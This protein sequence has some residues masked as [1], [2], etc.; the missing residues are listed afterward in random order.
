MVKDWN[1]T[2]QEAND[3]F[4]IKIE[5]DGY[6]NPIYIGKAVLGT[7]VTDALWQIQKLTYSGTNPTDIQWAGGED[8]FENIWN[9]RASL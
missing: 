2:L 4:T 9:D 5:Y 6:N 7:A 1:A 8:R 3:N